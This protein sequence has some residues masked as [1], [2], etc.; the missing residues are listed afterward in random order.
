M[1]FKYKMLGW[2]RN[3]GLLKQADDFKFLVKRIKLSSRNKE[4]IRKNP[5]FPVPPVDLAF[6][7]YNN[8]DWEEYKEVGRLHARVFTDIINEQ[9][10][11]GPLKIL[12]WGCG[13]GRLVRHL[14]DLISGD[15]E[16]HGSDYN[17]ETID[18][19]Q[20]NLKDIH[21]VKNGIKP[22]LPYK[23]NWFDAIY[24]F[25]VFTH[26]TEENQIEW[27]SEL[28]R[29]L[30]PGGILICSTHGDHYRKLLNEN[31][32]AEYD[33]GRL[34]IQDRYSEGKKWFFAIHPRSFV[35][36]TLLKDF[37]GIRRV[38]VEP[39]ANMEQDLWVGQK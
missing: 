36:S 12:E 32:L 9:S 26:L 21:F 15:P 25:S 35:E 3:V 39:E 33:A 11:G 19:C 24:N 8:F 14:S 4:F 20:R 2:I 17:P 13:P 30:K 38:N 34:V 31:E 7:A 29:I 10:S 28:K 16:I 18:W 37:K 23:E 27:A 5:D 1:A 22:P 6:D